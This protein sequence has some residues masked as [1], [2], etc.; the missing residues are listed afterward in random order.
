MFIFL[1]NI[2]ESLYLDELIAFLKY[3]NDKCSVDTLW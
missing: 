3:S 2:A 1:S